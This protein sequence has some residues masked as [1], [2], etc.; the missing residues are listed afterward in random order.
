MTTQHV[1]CANIGPRERQKRLVV[2]LVGTAVALATAGYLV[3]A[4]APWWAGVATLPFFLGGALGVFQWQHHTC[5]ANVR[6]G[7]RNMDNGDEPVTDATL[8]R[9]LEI[10]AQK[11]QAKSLLVGVAGMALVMLLLLL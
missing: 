6:R 7:V 3:A 1:V 10:E 2:G 11:V 8:Q 4:N 9:A 5:I